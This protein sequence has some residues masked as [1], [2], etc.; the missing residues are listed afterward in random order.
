MDLLAALWP[1]HQHLLV[2]QHH[3]AVM[4]DSTTT[5]D[6]AST[7]DSSSKDAFAYTE[8]I[9]LWTDNKKYWEQF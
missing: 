1:V 4:Q 9:K 2:M 5:T 8:I 6:T 3:L 7:S